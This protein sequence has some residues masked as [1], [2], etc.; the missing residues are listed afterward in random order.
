MKKAIYILIIGI[1]MSC[2]SKQGLTEKV[3]SISDTEVISKYEIDGFNSGV[4]LD[5]KKNGEFIYENQD[6]G[7]TGG[8]HVQRIRGEFKVLKDK[9]I[10]NPKSLI[11]IHYSGFD[12]KT[13]EKD[14]VKYH[15]SDSIYIKKEYQIVKWDSL[16]YLLSEEY[17]SNWGY[18]E[19]EN[20]FEIFAD[21]YN[22]GY[23]P[24]NS[25]SYFVK[26][27]RGYSPKGQFDKSTIPLKYQNRFLEEP[28][29]AEIIE[30]SE[31]KESKTR[32]LYK[33]NKGRKDG[34][35]EKM[36]FYGHDGCC[37]IR[38]TKIENEVSYGNIYLCFDYQAEC[39]KGERVTTYLE[40]E[41]GKFEN[42]H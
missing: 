3:I 27:K 39:G 41:K 30:V 6:W 37:S 5:L 4:S 13:I 8:G 20:D 36:D 7:C 24:E 14:S 17:F 16:R 11:D 32:R 38:I 2:Q 28:I 34:V 42:A 10:L 35:L 23:E 25:G 21:Y 19:N 40:R 9:L 26:R 15:S 22:S 1:L 33:L 18:E 12:K 31:N 29:V